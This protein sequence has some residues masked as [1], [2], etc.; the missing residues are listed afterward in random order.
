[1]IS[2]YHNICSEPPHTFE[3]LIIG[4]LMSISKR[5]IIIDIVAD[6][7][8]EN[9][10]KPA[11]RE[12]RGSSDCILVGS[13]K[14]R[15]PPDI[16][17]FFVNMGDKSQLTILIFS[18]IKSNNTTCLAMLK[19]KNLFLSDNCIC[20]SDS[21]LKVSNDGVTLFNALSSEHKEADTKFVS[22]FLQVL[23]SSPRNVCTCF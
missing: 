10:I 4:F 14:S 5:H 9:S 19:C 16:S 12:K 23:S 1:M 8:K 17:N 11:E 3:E 18:Y 22:Y 6:C 21:R 7:Y 13:V 2:Q 15:I 20:D